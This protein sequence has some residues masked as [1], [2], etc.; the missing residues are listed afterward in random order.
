MSISTARLAIGA[1]AGILLAAVAPTASDAGAP[2][3][4]GWAIVHADGTLGSR[5]NVTQVIHVGTG[6]Y[7]VEFNQDVSHCAATATIAAHGGKTIVP[8]YI[9]AGRNSTAPNQVRVYTFESVT[10]VPTD[11]K[12]DVL[13]SCA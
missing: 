10:L 13:A 5:S 7:R 2:T 11:Y 6:I 12:F 4:G 8:G 3:P 9:V 1:A